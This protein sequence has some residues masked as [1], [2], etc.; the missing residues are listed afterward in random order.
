MLRY[1]KQIQTA[2]KLGSATEHTYRPALKL[3]VESLD[4][5]VTATNEPKRVRCG[6]PDFVVTRGQI[7]IGYVE[8]KDIGVPL[9]KVEKSEQMR[10]YLEGL[11]NLVL[12]HYVEF[13]WY[14]GGQHRLTGRVADLTEKKTLRVRQNE[15]LAVE[16]LLHSFLNAEAPMVGSPKELAERMAALA[17]LARGL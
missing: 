4:K 14:L 15:T 5:G 9:D 17:G 1:L 6:A 13:R 16:K 8:A 3:L 11:G 10:R 7:P 2:L 12:T